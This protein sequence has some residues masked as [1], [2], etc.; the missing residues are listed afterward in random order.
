M[1]DNHQCVRDH[2]EYPPLRPAS[3]IGAAMPTGSL[4]ANS[5]EPLTMNSAESTQ[6][7]PHVHQTQSVKQNSSHTTPEKSFAEAVSNATAN[8]NIHHQPPDLRKFFLADHIPQP[9]GVKSLIGGRPT[10]S[11]TD[12]ETEELAAPY[13]FSLVGKFSHGAPPYSQMHQLIARLGIQGAF[14]VSM[15]NSK[16]TLISLTSESDYSRLWLRRIWFL[17]GFPMRVF[18]WTPTF[19]PTQESSVVPIWVSFPELPAHLFRKDALFSIASMIGSPLQVDDLTLNKS[20]LSLARA[21]G[22][23]QTRDIGKKVLEPI[24]QAERNKASST[25]EKAECSKASQVCEASENTKHH[26]ASQGKNV[27]P[28]HDKI[29]PASVSDCNAHTV[30]CNLRNE[31]IADHDVPLSPNPNVQNCNDA[32]DSLNC[33]SDSSNDSHTYDN[34][35]AIGARGGKNFEC[36]ENIETDNDTNWVQV[37][38]A[39]MLLENITEEG[40]FIDNPKEDVHLSEDSEGEISQTETGLGGRKKN[41]ANQ[42]DVVSYIPYQNC[43]KIKDPACTL[44]INRIDTESGKKLLQELSPVSESSLLSSDQKMNALHRRSKS[45]GSKAQIF[46]LSKPARLSKKVTFLTKD[47]SDEP[48]SS[49]SLSS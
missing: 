15:I 30:V 34:N 13:R 4:V 23:K 44:N 46:K 9:I 17:Q 5:A 14:T 27:N 16:H 22:K 48:D 45:G 7:L 6:D 35:H 29:A 25:I 31:G 32:G 40:E 3:T 41:S 39:F 26:S 12:A 21:L 19:T 49:S 20:K 1:A 47:K 10:L 28:V 24:E 33:I 38:N 18:K 36:E 43:I 2:M 42:L 8:R 37:G 11:F